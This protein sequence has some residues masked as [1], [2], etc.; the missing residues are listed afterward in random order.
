MTSSRCSA[1]DIGHIHYHIYI[2]PPDLKRLE[3]LGNVYGV[4][5]VIS[6]NHL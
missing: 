1:N 5:S 4:L 6:V 2:H 3:K